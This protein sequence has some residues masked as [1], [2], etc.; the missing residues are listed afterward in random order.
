[1]MNT[2]C[3][4]IALT[5]IILTVAISAE[6]VSQDSLG[7]ALLSRGSLYGS[8][9]MLRTVPHGA[10]AEGERLV[11]DVGYSFITAGEAVMSI[12]KSDSM[13]G[14]SVYQVLFT[15][16]STKTFSWIYKVDDRYETY[17]DV[18]GIFPWHFTQRVREGSYS[19]DFSAWFDQV[20]NIAYSGDK[21]YPIPPYVHDAVSAFYFIR[22]L[23]YSKSR[24]GEKMMLQNFFRDTTYSLEVKFLGRQRIEVDAGT[25]NCII[26][27]P[28]MKEGGLFKSEGRVLIWLTDDERKIPVKVSTKVVVGSIDAELREYSGING[29]IGAKVR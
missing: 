25:F 18:L 17:L 4:R 19:R 28:L 5:A 8:N 10:F 1:M 6:V 3:G 21:Q 26:V 22:T 15:V 14:R 2:M 9:T 20:K 27:E 7:R 16:N 13:F 12:P 24:I 29:P 11:F 23:D